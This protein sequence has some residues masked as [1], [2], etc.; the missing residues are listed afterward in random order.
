MHGSCSLSSLPLLGWPFK[1]VSWLETGTNQDRGRGAQEWH[2]GC[3]PLIH[4]H[5]QIQCI[6][7]LREE[8]NECVTVPVQAGVCISKLQLRFWRHFILLKV[9][10]FKY[11]SVCALGNCLFCFCLK[12]PWGLG[13]IWAEVQ[14]LGIP[15]ITKYRMSKNK[16]LIRKL[17]FIQFGVLKQFQYRKFNISAHLCRTGEFLKFHGWILNDCSNIQI[18]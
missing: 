16:G 3:S 14:R 2:C 7:A 10:N 11:S 18:Y 15:T 6:K 12:S 8:G 17:V 4:G 1:C 5:G 9:L 13:V